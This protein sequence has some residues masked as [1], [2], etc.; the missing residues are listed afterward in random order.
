MTGIQLKLHT[1]AASPWFLTLSIGWDQRISSAHS[2]PCPSVGGW[3]WGQWGLDKF[4]SSPFLTIPW[5]L[6][7]NGYWPLKSICRRS[8]TQACINLHPK[9]QTGA[10]LVL[11]GL[12]FILVTWWIWCLWYIQSLISENGPMVNLKISLIDRNKCNSSSKQWLSPP[13]SALLLVFSISVNVTS[14]H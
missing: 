5:Y 10:E 8:P 12:S 1:L 14:G 13:N 11:V 3:V 4:M 6:P 7:S 9:S 2:W